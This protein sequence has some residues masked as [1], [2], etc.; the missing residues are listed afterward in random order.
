MFRLPLV[1]F[2]LFSSTLLPE[3]N[4]W[5]LPITVRILNRKHISHFTIGARQEN[6]AVYLIVNDRFPYNYKSTSY[7]F[8][9]LFSEAKKAMDFFS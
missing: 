7:A 2:F 8:Y 6:Y 9:I 4:P 1:L 3:T 5:D